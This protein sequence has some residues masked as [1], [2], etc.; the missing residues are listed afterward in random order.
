MEVDSRYSAEFMILSRIPRLDESHEFNIASL[1]KLNLCRFEVWMNYGSLVSCVAVAPNPYQ[2]YHI[3]RHSGI[4]FAELFP[5]VETYNE[6][7]I[8]ADCEAKPL[9]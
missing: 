9:A 5:P 3:S 4:D 8:N 7:Q 6:P 1:K 2:V